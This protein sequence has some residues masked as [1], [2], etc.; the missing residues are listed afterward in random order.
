MRES[1]RAYYTPNQDELAEIWNEGLVVLDTNALLNL[2]RYTQGTREEFLSVL[3]KLS[4]S[5]WLPNHV[6]REF[7]RRRLDV[8]FT[9]SEA[10]SKIIDSLGRAE[11]EIKTAANAFKHHP[12]INRDELLEQVSEFFQGLAKKLEE[13]HCAHDAQIIANGGAEETFQR[14]S[15]LFEGKVGVA[16]TRE[17]CAAICAEGVTRYEEETPPGYRDRNNKNENEYGDLIIWKE[18]LRHG[19]ETTRPVIFVT[20]DRKD[21]WWWKSHGETRGPRVELVDEFWE[22][23]HRRVH[24]YEPLRFLEYAKE[25]VG[26][27]ISSQSLEEVQEVSS[28][29]ESELRSPLQGRDTIGERLTSLLLELSRR[30]VDT[31]EPS[32]YVELFGSLDS[33]ELEQRST[34]HLLGRVRGEVTHDADDFHIHR[35]HSA[36]A[37]IADQQEVA[38][39]LERR[40]LALSRRREFIERQLHKNY[41]R[42]PQEEQRLRRQAR[43]LDRELNEISRVLNELNR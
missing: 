11:N 34:A 14:I 29:D 39:S 22:S 7:H 8:V 43:H 37:N 1:F 28:A 35:S 26:V 3:E 23:A 30:G 21:D 5:L 27:E 18:I 2:F 41:G 10:F 6:A 17:E 12:S 32:Q 13:Q 40:F 16:F 31:N 4:G 15:T 20:D 38:A 36:S 9:T 19:K 25:Q 24:F 33:P 42:D